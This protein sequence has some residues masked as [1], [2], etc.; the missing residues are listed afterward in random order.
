MI[1]RQY[2]TKMDAQKEN[3]AVRFADMCYYAAHGESARSRLRGVT[4]IELIVVVAILS[5]LIGLLLPAVQRARESAR[6]ARCKNNL[7]Q[8]GIGLLQHHE[9]RSAFPAGCSPQDSDTPFLAWAV[10][11]YPYVEQQALWDI[12]VRD[13]QGD[14]PFGF[15][16]HRGFST[17]VSVFSCP[18]DGRAETAHLTRF[19]YV[20]A[21]TSYLGV[22]GTDLQT[23]DGVLFLDSHIRT[24]DIRDGTS[25]TVVVGERPP[26]RDF[27]WGWLYA[28]LGQDFSGSGDMILGVREIN[29]RRDL[30]ADCDHDRLHF[31]AGSLDNPC[32]V[33]HFWSLHPQGALFLFADGHVDM[34]AY[35][36]AAMLERAATR[37]NGLRQ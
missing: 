19:R 24:V 22:E 13:F 12:A 6:Q 26:S 17:P 30:G 14:R 16:T 5:I 36:E 18:S 3:A 2:A 11:I 32:S 28:G 27:W 21:L 35:S 37:A 33:L 9:A 34:I 25:Q 20:A 8:I 23:N 31:Q 1:R 29:R 15:T 10:Q 4:L 7:R